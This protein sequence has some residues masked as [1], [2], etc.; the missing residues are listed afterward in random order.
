MDKDWKVILKKAK[1]IVLSSNENWLLKNE[2]DD[3][4]NLIYKKDWEKA[5]CWTSCCLWCIF[6][7][8]WIIYAILWGTNAIKKQVNIHIFNWELTIS[9]DSS[10]IINVYNLLKNSEVWFYLKENDE[11]I[12]AKKSKYIS[13]VILFILIILLLIIISNP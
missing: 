8:M 11:I 9:W 6:L 12:K 13:Y 1:N 5:W 3:I 2:D 4:V 10:L 7:P